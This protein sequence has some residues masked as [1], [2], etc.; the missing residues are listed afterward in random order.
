MPMITTADFALAISS[1]SMEEPLP[2]GA[3]LVQSPPVAH[4]ALAYP[5]ALVA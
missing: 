2:P 4:P 1:A 3:A 5:A